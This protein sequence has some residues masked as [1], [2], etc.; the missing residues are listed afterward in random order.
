MTVQYDE[1]VKELRS[2][3]NSMRE[4]LDWASELEALAHTARHDQELMTPQDVQAHTLRIR[5]L[6][7]K[8]GIFR[9]SVAYP[10]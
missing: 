1:T 7:A 4:I 3:R 10:H 5:D 9:D 2:V 8:H 6:C